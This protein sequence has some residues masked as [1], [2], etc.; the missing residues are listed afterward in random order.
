MVR[1]CSGHW[2]RY[3]HSSRWQRW[4]LGGPRSAT[5]AGQVPTT[6]TNY[7]GGVAGGDHYPRSYSINGR[8]ATTEVPL[9][10]KVNASDNTGA[11]GRK[12]GN[13]SQGAARQLTSITTR[14]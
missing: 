8:A 2:P 13:L 9:L 6:G 4:R 14:V 1:R 11:D 5:Y 3:P 12:V 10:T 7:C